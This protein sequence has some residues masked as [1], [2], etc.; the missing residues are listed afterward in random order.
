MVWGNIQSIVET[1]CAQSHETERFCWRDWKDIIKHP[2]FIHSRF[3]V[4]AR[5]LTRSLSD[6]ESQCSRDKQVDSRPSKEQAKVYY[7][8][9]TSLYIIKP[10]VKGKVKAWKTAYT[11]KDAACM[12][13]RCKT[14]V[15]E[16]EK[17]RSKQ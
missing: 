4:Y 11:C 12:K 14:Y 16:T 10:H 3:Q 5:I 8:T 13:S 15:L 9:T 17:K 1:G 6:T 7:R 2:K